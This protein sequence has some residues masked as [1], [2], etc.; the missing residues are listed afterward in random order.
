MNTM[1]RFPF[2]IRAPFIL[3]GI[4]V[5]VSMLSIAQAIILPVM[6][7]TIIAILISPAVDFLERKKVNRAIAIAGVL[8]I[9]L[10]IIAAFLGW[11]FSQAG[12]L[13]DA[14]PLLTDKFQEFIS[15]LVKWASGYFN[16]RVREINEWL[17]REKFNLLNNGIGIGSTFST[18]TGM[19]ATVFLTPVYIF[20]ILYYQ[21]HLIRFTHLLF[22][23]DH[24]KNV[25]EILVETKA[26]VQNYLVGL[27]I[28][29]VIIA[30]LNS[31]GLLLLGIEYAILL[32]IIGAL[33]NVIP[34]LGGLTAVALYMVIALVTMSPVYVLYV[35]GLYA[36]IQFV[37]NNYI[38]PKIIGSKVKLNAFISILAVISG[39]ALWGIPGMFLSIPAT[40]VFKLIFDRVESMKAWGFLLGDTMPPMIKIM[41]PGKG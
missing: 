14:L 12:L 25:T 31:V 11:V 34:Y 35:M 33:L 15:Q 37:D 18:M 3:V 28:E 4:Y 8:V 32:G 17:T 21:P 27:F 23:T 39:A 41:K 36:V 24:D 9:A 38:V 30:M 22:G 7:A 19:L 16:I 20:M 1:Q 13:S 5:L 29:F 26:I 6:Y 40:A 10:L 2:Y